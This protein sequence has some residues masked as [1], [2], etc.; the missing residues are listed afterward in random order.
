MTRRVSFAITFA[1]LGFLASV[2]GAGAAP[3]AINNFSF[4]A[5]ALSAGSWNFG[6][7]AI[8]GWGAAYGATADGVQ[9][10]TFGQ[11]YT[12]PN[13][14]QAMYVNYNGGQNGSYQDVGPLQANTTY[15]LSV[16]VGERAD[17]LDGGYAGVSLLNG[18]DYRGAPLAFGYVLP[19]SMTP[20]FFQPLSLTYTTGGS[21]SGDLT[22]YLDQYL[23]SPFTT[24]DSQV[25][26]ADVTLDA[27]AASTGA[28]SVPDASPWALLTTGAAFA[29]LLL[30]RRSPG[31]LLAR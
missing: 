6:T 8:P 12:I 25:S 4:A 1:A 27:A 24:G 9:A 29:L 22:I 13:S 7:N 17:G 15:T 18:T 20:G 23:Q 26:F 19:S 11:Y 31:R 10:Y 28:V 21:V 30:R 16:Y 5:P 3:I 14:T 2:A